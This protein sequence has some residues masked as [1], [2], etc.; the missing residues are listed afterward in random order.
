MS[1]DGKVEKKL[2]IENK[3]GL[4]ARPVTE[5]VQLANKFDSKLE[6]VKDGVAVDAKSVASMLTLGAE[7]GT[8]L[9]IRA[10]GSDAAEALE[11]LSGLI[12]SKFG[13]E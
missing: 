13:E 1:D 2:T 5:F 9:W 10:N 4:H 11:K 12:T 3:Y 7:H 8:R 6:V